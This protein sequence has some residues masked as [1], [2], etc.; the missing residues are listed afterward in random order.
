M[1]N[2]NL[3]SDLNT[4]K[5]SF[6][7]YNVSRLSLLAAAAAI[8]DE[9][10]Y[11]DCVKKLV[12]TRGRMVAELEK[13]GFSVLPSK[14]NF[15]FAKPAFTGGEDYYLGLKERGVLVRHFTLERIKDFVRI[16]M[17]SDGQMDKLLS[18]TDDMM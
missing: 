8:K 18:A 11:A 2:E 7:P 14:A 15:L 17:G 5:F 9:K 10:Y 16:T 13:R 6:N 4:M 3:I 12:G 1:A